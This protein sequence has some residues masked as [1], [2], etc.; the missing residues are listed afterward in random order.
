MTLFPRKPDKDGPTLRGVL[1]D[2][3][4]DFSGAGKAALVAIVLVTYVLAVATGLV[5]TS[6]IFGGLL[7]LGWNYGLSELVNAAGG[8]TDNISFLEGCGVALI[9]AALSILFR[10]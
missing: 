8:D 10:R 1:A 6:A 4:R 9:L 2:T 3:S 5:I 7:S